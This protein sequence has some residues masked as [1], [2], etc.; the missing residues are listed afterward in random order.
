MNKQW[1]LVD[2]R[3]F[4]K[5]TVIS[6]AFIGRIVCLYREKENVILSSYLTNLDMLYII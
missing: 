1:V 5:R 3:H 4:C 2:F 6:S